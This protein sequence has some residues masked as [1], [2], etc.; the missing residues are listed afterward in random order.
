MKQKIKSR[1]KTKKRNNKKVLKTKNKNSKKNIKQQTIKKIIEK[2]I[3]LTSIILFLNLSYIYYFGKINTESL[4]KYNLVFYFL[5][6]II[7]L[8]FLFSIIL[9]EKKF[10]IELSLIIILTNILISIINILNFYF[11]KNTNLK[12]YNYHTIMLF[13]SITILLIEFI[14]SKIDNIKLKNLGW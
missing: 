4:K 9:E 12:E 8:L 10:I 11:E 5:L 1:R 7:Y 13:L 2:Y 3:F 14:S 6:S